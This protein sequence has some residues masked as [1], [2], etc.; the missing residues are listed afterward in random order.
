MLTE[1]PHV[2]KEFD[3]ER[4][5]GMVEFFFGLYEGDGMVVRETSVWK[6]CNKSSF[7]NSALGEIIS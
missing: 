1:I 3:K 6:V 4:A 2:E 7:F 5:Q